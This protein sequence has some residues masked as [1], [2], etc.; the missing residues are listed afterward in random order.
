MRSVV[1]CTA[2]QIKEEWNGYG[3]W[4]VWGRREMHAGFWWGNL[5]EIERLEDLGL[6]EMIMLTVHLKDT[7]WDDEDWIDLAQVRAK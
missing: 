6:Y 2:H 7:E 3:M 1:I 4:H 5:K